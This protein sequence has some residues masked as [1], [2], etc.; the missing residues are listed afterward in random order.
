M[1]T[2][3]LS[4][5]SV[6]LKVLGNIPFALTP[7]A[8]N[9]SGA[10]SYASQHPLV[11][12]VNSTTGVVTIVGQGSATIT[13]TQAAHGGFTSATE[14]A[15]LIVLSQSPLN[16][17]FSLLPGG[18]TLPANSGLSVSGK[19]KDF[20]RD[21]KFIVDINIPSSTM[22]FY[23]YSV[24]ID[25]LELDSDGQEYFFDTYSI[26]DSLGKRVEGS[27]SKSNYSIIRDNDKGFPFVDLNTY[28][29]KHEVEIKETTDDGDNTATPPVPPTTVT[30]IFS[31]TQV[32]RYYENPVKLSDFSF[33]DNV[34]LG[35]DLT[36]T[37]LVLD[38]GVNSPVD[39]TEPEKVK[40]TFNRIDSNNTDP[41]IYFRSEQDFNAIGNYTIEL[42]P[43]VNPQGFILGN[44]YSVRADASWELGYS[45][46]KKSSQSLNLLSRPEITNIEVLPLSVDSSAFDAGTWTNSNVAQLGGSGAPTLLGSSNTTNKT[47]SWSFSQA[48]WVSTSN[49]NGTR[50]ATYTGSTL[51]SS[52]FTGPVTITTTYGVDANGL[53]NTDIQFSIINHENQAVI[54][55]SVTLL[56]SLVTNSTNK[57][58]KGKVAFD[59]DIMEITLAELS[60][61]GSVDAP[62][63]VWFEF[64][65]AFDAGTWTNS[66]VVQLGGSGAPTLLG[67]SNTSNQMGSWSFSQATWV[68]PTVT[69]SNGTR[70]ATYTGGT[71]TSRSFTGPVT[72]TTT[73]GVNANGLPN[74][75]IQFS[76]INPTNQA[77]IFSS[78]TLLSSLVPNST[79][80]TLTGTVAA[81]DALVARAGGDPEASGPGV[82][83]PDSNIILLKLSD[84][85]TINGV[86]LLNS[87][88]Y[89]VIAKIKYEE[90][91]PPVFRDSD[92]YE[93]VNF[94]LTTPTISSI[95]K[96][97][98][99]IRN[100]GEEIATITVN[101]D[102]YEL[103]APH[104]TAG[105]E[106][107]FYNANGTIEVARTIAYDFV[108]T[109][110][111]SE[112]TEYPIKL[113]EI[114]PT[115]GVYLT[116]GVNYSVKAQVTL[117]DHS[118]NPVTRLSAA[119]STVTFN[120][121]EPDISSIDKNSLSIAVANEKIATITVDHAA[122]ELYAPYYAAGI[123]FVFYDGATEVARTSA[124]DFVNT[125]VTGSQPYPIKLNEITPTSGVYLE[126]GITYTVKA[127]VKVTNHA[128]TASDPETTSYV[129]S[130]KSSTVTFDLVHPVISSVTPYDVQD[131]G[132]NDGVPAGNDA[133]SPSQIVAT[134]NLA[135]ASYN[136]Y[137]PN[138]TDGILFIFY[139]DNE[140]EVAITSPYNFSNDGTN[141]YNIQLID[142]SGNTLLT[143]GTP[144]KV[145]AQ[146]TLVDHNGDEE[147]R[148]S[149]NFF[150]V[151]FTQNIAPV[152][153]LNIS[154]TWALVSDNDPET[155]PTEF[156]ASPIIGISG[157]FS[158][159]AQFGS[160]YAVYN[161]DLDTTS[162]KFKLEYKVTSSNPARVTDWT[163]VK[164][165]SLVLQGSSVSNEPLR[166]A[167]NR[168]RSSAGTLSTVNSGEYANIPGTGPGT[169]QGDIVFFIPQQQEGSTDAFDE[170][171]VVAVRVTVINT[172][173]PAL[174]GGDISSDPYAAIPVHV[175][176]RIDQYNYT[177]SESSEPWNSV[178]VNNNLLINIPV[179]WN[180]Y[181]SHSV[182]VSYNYISDASNNYG[183]AL[184]IL[185]GD[186]VESP[187]PSK[188]SFVV[189]PT[190]GTTHTLYY[191][192]RY[193]VTNPNLGA[194]AT[195][196]GIFTKKDVDNKFFP[197]SSDY[198]V[199]DISY[200]TFNDDSES[201][202][203]FTLDLDANS[204]NRL[205]G[206]NVY[207]TS[208]DSN[209]EPVR[210]G[211]YDDDQLDKEITL[212]VSSGGNLQVLDTDGD[213]IDSGLPWDN[214]TSANISFKAYRDARVKSTDA[215]Y[216]PVS[217]A[218]DPEESD[219]YVESGG[220]TTFGTS[221]DSNPIW[222]IPVLTTPGEDGSV[223]LSGGVINTDP[224][225]NHFISW[226]A[227]T[228][229]DYT[230]N[231][232]MF[233]DNDL[234]TAIQ[235]NNGLMP[236]ANNIIKE[237][238]DID[239]TTTAKYTVNIRKVF[240][241]EISEPTVIVFHTI[242]I[243]TSN[244]AVSVIN[245]SNTSSVK[246]SWF[247]PDIS[248]NS[249]QSSESSF[250]SFANN[251]STQ[252]IKYSV[253][254]SGSYARL[255]EDEDPDDV[256]AS[257]KSYTLP[258]EAVPGTLLEFVMFIEANVSYTVDGVLSSTNSTSHDIPLTPEPPTTAS[259]YLVSSIPSVDVIPNSD[260]VNIVPVLVQGSSNPTL[261]LNLNANGL[262][263]E[264]FISVV[265]ILTQDGSDT[266]PE[267]EQALLIFPD[268]PDPSPSPT[269]PLHPFS[270][271]NTVTGTGGAGTGDV[272]LAGG[273]SATSVPRNITPS[274][275]S[276][277]PNDN[278]YTLTIGT[279]Q[280]TGEDAGRY[281]LSTL[282]MPSSA[283][284]GFVGGSPVN[285][286]V[287][288]TTRRG[289]DIGVGEFVYEDLP[290]VENVEIVTIDGQYFVNFVIN[291]A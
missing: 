26:P 39:P 85:D 155:Y 189:D 109:L 225:S 186:G 28:S 80:K 81:G 57:T 105:I 213:T 241:D 79:N 119:F 50:T 187:Y 160:A 204:M 137:A 272:R 166:E 102:A 254:S 1:T 262:E 103:Y 279:V 5:F 96:N 124:Y 207:F 92:P 19:F 11:A 270:F 110:T 9:S 33:D 265:V 164:K 237:E 219:F 31:H 229:Q 139:D 266:K 42:P 55:S 73:Y 283:N 142:I 220:Q 97:P 231:L 218:S 122:Y 87:I 138:V 48:T 93:D 44:S 156:Q 275:L 227:A 256:E 32:F 125:S 158:K 173:D 208:T 190:Q 268:F 107:I 89:S 154:N 2:P 83:I 116:H 250:P 62:S 175:I 98:L 284:S 165:A 66:N 278:N 67:S 90:L 235:T 106:F 197:E 215:S 49:S 201:S 228:D 111:S 162:T 114:T 290:S 285:Y 45:T 40:F 115:N 16:N 117:T 64:Y 174:W 136:L 243:N 135:D 184:V 41:N 200:N 181:Y 252:Y 183:A 244:M 245:P 94:D 161:K 68:S 167:A 53:P 8:S 188:V 171:D 75:D 100:T 99:Y 246:L 148:L 130:S 123:L 212:L 264:G 289:T 238:L 128:G 263:T 52:S 222:N 10:F 104:E 36:I 258:S 247:E 112:T 192:V 7:P 274:V 95:D 179:S 145:K 121:T 3:T 253:G 209:I 159:N 21:V 71:L 82:T 78:V 86:G 276:T 141:L 17:P 193:V 140:D 196:N 182:E 170:T 210:I 230:Y 84:I 273:D 287:I 168:A 13:A 234:V 18:P 4:N 153:S 191:R 169:S 236:G 101:H 46:S 74:T 70:T 14:E 25:S 38:H 217:T 267:G 35:D 37:G 12:T 282:Q 269:H 178:D 29:I 133:D 23:K 255:D 120:L 24:V 61:S 206:V 271:P 221:S 15:T 288:L 20:K 126:N 47:G 224:S 240:E 152:I 214:Y 291:P 151:T 60:S 257:P 180:S 205:D 58:L 43:S 51:S 149:E 280:T 239:L 69:N 127:A 108:N 65:A 281:G 27:F 77:V 242:R 131:D 233:K 91:N 76:I 216:N 251:I 185:R 34:A 22:A 226:T 199:S 150:D 54:F 59:D 177:M 261:L 134:I 211:T 195:T 277:D 176:K 260:D 259:Q 129:V 146:V 63:K 198:V 144:Y 232:E 30:H 203:T 147:L 72:I 172:T 223:T 249:V 286:M 118:S 202:I 6:P 132:G 157:N 88:D 248:G 143:N 56:S 113:S 194:G 163:T